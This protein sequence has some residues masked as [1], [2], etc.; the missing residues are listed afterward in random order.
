MNLYVRRLAMDLADRGIAVDVFTRRID[1][2]TPEIVSLSSGA[3]LVQLSAGP[4]RR[5]PKSVL[6]LH[7]PSVASALRSFATREG[8]GYD[9]LHSH[10]WISGLVAVRCRAWLG[11]RV[12]LVHMFHTLSKLKTLHTAE[13]DAGDSD[14]RADGERC[15]IPRADAIV[16]S[17]SEERTLMEQLYGRT[18]NRF[19]MIPPGVDHDLFRPHGTKEARRALGINARRVI[20]F[21]GRFDRLK[22]LDVLLRSVESLPPE[23]KCGLKVL[24]VG[25]STSR[26]RG[27]AERYRSLVRKLGLD[28]VVSFR[29]RADQRLLPVYYS[30]ADVCAVPSAYESFG[31]V[32]ME[33][34]ACQTPVVAFRVGGLARTIEHGR[35]GL[36]ANP[37]DAEDYARN[38]NAALR[39]ALWEEVGRRARFSIR[40]Y[41]WDSV[42]CRTLELYEDLRGAGRRFSF[43]STGSGVGG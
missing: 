28:E 5:L 25:G 36:L 19:E 15:L 8:I 10:Y 3:R 43:A 7:I 35:T 31:M 17:T 6:P 11:D 34:M 23:L 32:A 9:L 37:G 39:H 22:G 33:S 16:G 42:A 40:E 20:L 12:P 18:A 26:E 27:S 38:L 14:L 13:P 2:S 41:T 30:A 29:G 21:V 4:R 1:G 24:L